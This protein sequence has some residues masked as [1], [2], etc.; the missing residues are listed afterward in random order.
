MVLMQIV[1][2]LSTFSIPIQKGVAGH[3][4]RTGQIQNITDARNHEHFT[5][6]MDAMT[7]YTTQ[8]LLCA[9]LVVR[10]K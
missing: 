5:P 8:T 3:C 4:A 7:G 1:H 10:G 9:P 6:E 2:V